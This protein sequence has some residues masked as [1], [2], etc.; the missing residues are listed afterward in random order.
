MFVCL[1]FP[2]IILHLDQNNSWWHD[3]CGF[4][5][6]FFAVHRCRNYGFPNRVCSTKPM[7][8]VVWSTRCSTSGCNASTMRTPRLAHS[9]LHAIGC[10]CK[11]GYA[12]RRNWHVERSSC[13]RREEAT[14]WTMITKMNLLNIAVITSILVLFV[15]E[16]TT[17]CIKCELVSFLLEKKKK[18]KCELLA[19]NLIVHVNWKGACKFNHFKPSLWIWPS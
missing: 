19:F 13:V 1:S 9:L 11:A 7:P 3:F 18:R 10:P 17:I 6:C 14:R 16:A 12:E 8:F 5:I 15:A 2:T 4:K